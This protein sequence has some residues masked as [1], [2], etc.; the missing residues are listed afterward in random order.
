M[1]KGRLFIA[2]SLI[3]VI[4]TACSSPIKPENLYGKW[5]YIKV[6]NPNRIPTDSVTSAELQIQAPYIQFTKN[7]SLIIYWG[8]KVLSHGTFKL[9]GSNIRYKEILADGKTR[10]FPFWVSKL[11]EKDL[12]FETSG[13]DGSRVTAVKE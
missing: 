13:E 10:A 6:T 2:L 3:G 12:I 8:G 7:D 11:T 4:L 9:D 1:I 5:K